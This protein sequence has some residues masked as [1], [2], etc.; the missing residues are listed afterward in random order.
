M[1][2]N[3]SY[4]VLLYDSCEKLSEKFKE[5]KSPRDVA[6]LLEVPFGDLNYYL[7]RKSEDSRYKTFIVPKKSGGSRTIYSPHTSLAIIQRKLSQVLYSV[8]RPRASVHGFAA[9]RSIITNAKAHTKKK[10]ILNLDIKDFFDAI[11]FG[12]VRGV[13]IGKPYGLNEQVATILA[14]ICC[15]NNKLPQGAPTSP[16]ISNL[17]CAKMDSEL[18]RF[19]EKYGLF[20]TRYADDITFSITRDELPPELVACYKKGLPKV[21]LGKEVRSIIE[22]NGFEVNDA[23]VRLAY[24]TQRQE[25]TGLIVNKSLNVN[26]KYIRNIYGTLHSWEKY[27]LEKVVEIYKSKYAKKPVLPEKDVPTFLDS[28]RGKIEFVGSVRGKNDDLYQKLLSIFNDLKNK[29]VNAE[30]ISEV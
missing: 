19:A 27:G 9:K 2:Q 21:V 8:Y 4:S 3:I 30:S 12:R 1:S 23:K 13:F 7:Y 25:V 18:Q 17:I 24:R 5:L 22:T 14:Q 28:L 16:I 20:Y 29:E 6:R 26:R 11:N 10:F 15:F